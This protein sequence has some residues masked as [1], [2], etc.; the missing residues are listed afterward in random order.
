MRKV[1]KCKECEHHKR[2]K[3]ARNGR[4]SHNCAKMNLEDIASQNTVHGSP[5]WCP[6]RK[7]NEHA[8]K[9]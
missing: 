2:I 9:I 8:N 7:V 5:V 4:Y 1:P 3:L 6:L